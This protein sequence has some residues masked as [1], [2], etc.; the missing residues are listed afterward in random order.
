MLACLAH[1]RDRI[2]QASTIFALSSVVRFY[3]LIVRFTT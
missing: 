3:P 2:V 1:H